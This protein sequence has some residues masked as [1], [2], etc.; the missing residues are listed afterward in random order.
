MNQTQKTGSDFPLGAE[1]PHLEMKNQQSSE[2]FN[3]NSA[4]PVLSLADYIRG[5]RLTN[6]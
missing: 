6:F 1:H 5:L 3:L 4:A 2:M